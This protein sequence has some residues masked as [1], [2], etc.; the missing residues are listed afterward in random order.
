MSCFVLIVGVLHFDFGKSFIFSITKHQSFPAQVYNPYYHT[1]T[2]TLLTTDFSLCHQLTLYRKQL[3]LK[4]KAV[5]NVFFWASSKIK[6]TSFHPDIFLAM[7]L[8]FKQNQNILRIPNMSSYNCLKSAVLHNTRQNLSAW[9]ILQSL[10][11][12]TLPWHPSF[13]SVGPQ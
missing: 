11:F 7:W 4:K 8:L 10:T 5:I 2:S 3:E 9:E 1:V 12:A 6:I 13:Q